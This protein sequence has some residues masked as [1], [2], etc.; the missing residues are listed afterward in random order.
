MT[1]KP[2]QQYSEQAYR[3]LQAA[4]QKPPPSLAKAKAFIS[5]AKNYNGSDIRCSVV[6]L[7]AFA[8]AALED[9]AAAIEMCRE[10]QEMFQVSGES[11]KRTLFSPELVGAIQRALSVTEHDDAEIVT[12]VLNHVC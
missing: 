12:W 3:M 7:S 8:R 2:D 4:C 11:P 9:P 6:I 5:A 10:F 1:G